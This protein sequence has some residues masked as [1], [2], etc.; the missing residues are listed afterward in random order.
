[1]AKPIGALCNLNCEYCFYLK[2]EHI[3]SHSNKNSFRMSKET[4]EAYV[5][6]YIETQ[7][8][9]LNEVIFAWQGG[10]PTLMD[11]SFFKEAIKLQQKYKRLGQSIKNSLQTNGT[12]ITEEMAKFYKDNNFLLGISVDGPENLHN[13]Y[14][15][16]P[17]GNGSFIKVMSGIELLKKYKVEFNTLTVLQ[18][19]NSK[20]PKEIYEFLKSIDSTYL[21][22]I[23]IVEKDGNDTLSYRTVQPEQFGEFMISLFKLWVIN[24]IGKIFI[25]HFDMLLG[26]Y[27][28]YPSSQCVHSKTCGTA[29]AM[30]HNGDLY[31]CD[32][33]VNPENKIGNLLVDNMAEMINSEKQT[34]F[35][36]DKF[37]SLPNKC[38]ECRYLPLCYG[39]CPKD[40]LKNN[41]NY[42]CEGYYKFYSFTEPYFKAMAT[43]LKMG[44]EAKDFRLFLQFSAKPKTKRNDPC[45]CLSGKKYKNC[46]GN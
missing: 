24:D 23:P 7:P 28:G 38:L 3:Y 15:K 41:I 2:K 12:L 20:H 37:N 40:R 11:L 27:M 39:A 17:K 8:E 32:H 22:F 45:H 4:L 44:K 29:I 42:L 16:D 46:C 13:K 31:S 36:N 5:K 33:F 14:R 25:G 30:E 10:E 21:Q 35:G 19:D 34:K 26:L 43:A 9:G 6:N 18:N 1:M